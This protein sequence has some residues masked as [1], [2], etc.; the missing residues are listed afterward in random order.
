MFFHSAELLH[1]INL[2]REVK[3]RS[4]PEIPEEKLYFVCP[5]VSGCHFFKL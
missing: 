5:T 2:E 1:Q 4:I 3:I